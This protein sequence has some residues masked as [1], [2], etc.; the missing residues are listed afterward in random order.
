MQVLIFVVAFLMV[1]T[2]YTLV[3]TKMYYYYNDVYNSSYLSY[4]Q[5]HCSEVDNL[6]HT[7][8]SNGTHDTS[9]LGCI[10]KC[11]SSYTNCCN[12][13]LCNKNDVDGTIF[14][15]M[16]AYVVNSTQHCYSQSWHSTA[17]RLDD[18]YCGGKYQLS[19]DAVCLWGQ[20]RCEDY[21]G[22]Y[23][24]TDY[25]E[26]LD[27]ALGCGTTR[28]LEAK[29]RLKVQGSDRLMYAKVELCS[30]ADNTPCVPSFVTKDSK[31]ATVVPAEAFATL[32]NATDAEASAAAA[33]PRLRLA[34]SFT[35]LLPF[36]AVVC[37]IVV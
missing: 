1:R 35:K 16:V 7:I 18:V 2:S 13:D 36:L 28:T 21:D 23:V 32:N 19:E 10:N 24:C 30:S 3:C 37:A 4:G 14:E 29:Q 27:I 9:L 6:C 33:A 12:S 15:N 26:M 5:Q 20:V 25:D 8:L 17:Y 34:F 22:E 11:H 31:I